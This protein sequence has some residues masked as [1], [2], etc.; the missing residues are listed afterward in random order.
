MLKHNMQMESRG[1]LVEVS[2][3]FYFVGPPRAQTQVFRPGCKPFLTEPSLC[4]PPCSPSLP[5]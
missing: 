3:L 4:T 1:W 2:S 5:L